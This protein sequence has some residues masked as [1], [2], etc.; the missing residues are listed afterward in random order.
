MRVELPYK[1]SVY[2]ALS[3]ARSQEARNYVT[4]KGAEQICACIVNDKM[5]AKFERFLNF[6]KQFLVTPGPILV[7][8]IAHFVQ[9]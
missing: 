2:F 4:N 5:T 3:N 1:N 8:S 6:S 9:Y 7:C